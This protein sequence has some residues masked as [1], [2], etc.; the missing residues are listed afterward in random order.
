M[1]SSGIELHKRF[2]FITTVDQRGKVLNQQRIRN[3][4]LAILEYFASFDEPHKAVVECTSNW[5]WI[6]DLLNNHGFSCTVAHAKYLK[7]IRYAKVKT[8][9]VDSNTL[10]QLLRME[11]IPTSY[12][13]PQELRPLR[14]LMR[15][16]L[17][18]VADRTRHIVSIHMTLGK[19]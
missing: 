4:D 12:Q 1:L 16:R 19:Y 14:D 6:S 7:A 8:D 10:A 13:V 5:Y 2:S 11:Y 17:K 18:L 15:Q 9:K 3:D